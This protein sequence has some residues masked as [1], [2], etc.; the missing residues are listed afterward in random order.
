MTLTFRGY[1]TSSITWPFDC[2]VAIS[3]RCSIVTKSL[4]PDGRTDRHVA[5]PNLWNSLPNKLR[6]AGISFQ[7]FKRLLKTFLFGCWDRGALWLTVK[8]TPHKFSY[9]LA[10]LSYSTDMLSLRL[11]VR[12]SHVQLNVLSLTPR[13]SEVG[14]SWRTYPTLTFL[15]PNVSNLK[16]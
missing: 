6:Q 2:H 4:S 9:L 1:V 10:Y 16:W 14:C 7:R 8:A 3:Y 11:S 12:L 5:D 15:N 13:S